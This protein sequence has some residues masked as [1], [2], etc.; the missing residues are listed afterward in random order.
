MA[1]R[2]THGEAASQAILASHGDAALASEPL[3]PLPL[4]IE[5]TNQSSFDALASEEFSVIDFTVMNWNS[6]GMRRG[7]I[8][9]AVALL[10]PE[11]YWDALTIQEGPHAITDEYKILPSG[12]A[13]FTAGCGAAGR[14]VSILVHKRWVKLGCQLSFKSRH[15]R[16][17]FVDLV[18]GELRLRL[19]SV[20]MPHAEFSDEDY[21]AVL[22]VLDDVVEQ[23]RSSRMTNLVGID[24]NAV[25]GVTAEGDRETVVGKYCVGERTSRG[26]MFVA[27]LHG[28]HLSAAATTFYREDYAL[29]WTHQQWGNGTCRQ[30]DFVLVDEIR[31]KDVAGVG[32]CTDLD[33]KSD[34][35]AAYVWFRFGARPI[36]Q[37][38]PWK[39]MIAWKP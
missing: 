23:A 24:A 18:C 19:I 4:V 16:I 31:V 39:L 32:V 2:N 6:C 28:N 27:W 33:G 14:S 37:R 21:D 10:K 5:E 3:P 25:I 17:A 9:D 1:T 30:I 26:D 35:R 11:T 15:K 34:H 13:F 36:M 20:H 12:H 22:M 38:R 7:A 29:Q 8:D